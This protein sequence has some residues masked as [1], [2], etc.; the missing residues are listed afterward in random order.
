M[1]CLFHFNLIL[2][3]IKQDPEQNA[4]YMSKYA[5]HSLPIIITDQSC[6]FIK[7]CNDISL[8]VQALFFRN[9]KNPLSLY[10]ILYNL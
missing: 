7:K 2:I 5:I 3:K 8:F 10:R 9:F 6:K 4:Q 1:S